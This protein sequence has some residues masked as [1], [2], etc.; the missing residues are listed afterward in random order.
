MKTEEKF[1]EDIYYKVEKAEAAEREKRIRRLKIYR[2]VSAAAACF[3]VAIGIYG[4]SA[5]GLGELMGMKAEEARYVDSVSAVDE[6]AAYGENIKNE[7]TEAKNPVGINDKAKLSLMSISAFSDGEVK[8]CNIDDREDVA[9]VEEWIKSLSPD[10][11]MGVEAFLSEYPDSNPGNY[12]VINITKET[13][14]LENDGDYLKETHNPDRNDI[15]SEE[16]E[17]YTI[18]TWYVVNAELPG[19]SVEIKN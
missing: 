15:D 10:E 9:R 16:D 3:I 14:S 7:N 19:L 13:K 4:Y 8:H 6:S 5:G 17:S 11:A 1:I 12:Y 2:S 18:L